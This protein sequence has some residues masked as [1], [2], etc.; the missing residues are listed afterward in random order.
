MPTQPQTFPNIADLLKRK[1]I[2][3]DKKKSQ[4][5]L[6]SQQVCFDIAELAELTPQD[7]AIE[8]GTGLGN[9]TVELGARAGRVVTIELDQ[10][11]ADW[12][13][14]L[15]ISYPAVRFLNQDFLETNIEQVVADNRQPG[16]IV[17]TGNLP[18][19]ITAEILFAFV[20]SPL[21]FDSLVFM[22]QKEVAERVAAGV[23]T[24]NSGALTYKIALR[25]HAEV[26]MHIG[27]EAFLPPPKV[28]SAVLVLKPLAVPLVPDQAGRDKVGHML[29]KLFHYRRKTLTNCLL[30]G[31]LAEGR[32]AAE[33]TLRRAGVEPIR[34][35][36]TLSL[37]EVLALAKELP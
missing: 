3:L 19:Q 31:G 13:H 12:H 23:G 30:Q 33:A 20:N 17:G 29:D 5:F 22:V 1:G 32:E 18:Y 8:V 36:E 26:K 2:W 7:L 16:R 27:P 24:R 21:T 9:L 35:P 14:Y 4:H 15:G 11:F 10:A 6:R 37:E 28:H 25:Y 34:R